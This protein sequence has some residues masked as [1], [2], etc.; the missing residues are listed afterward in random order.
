MRRTGIN[1]HNNT[2]LA[3]VEFYR[4]TKRIDC[5]TVSEELKLFLLIQRPRAYIQCFNGLM[6]Q[7]RF[8]VDPV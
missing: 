2:A 8:F 7:H 1:L 3:S 6:G 5:N 4:K